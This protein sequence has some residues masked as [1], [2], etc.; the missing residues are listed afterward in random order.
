MR[1]EEGGPMSFDDFMTT[2]RWRSGKPIPAAE[3]L[4]MMGDVPALD[5][6]AYSCR[7][8]YGSEQMQCAAIDH[9]GEA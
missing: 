9:G 3:L 7:R 1:L 2:A 6:W 4:R 5:A 8:A